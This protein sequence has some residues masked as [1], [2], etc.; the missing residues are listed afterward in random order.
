MIIH[1]NLFFEARCKKLRDMSQSSDKFDFRVI[2]LSNK[3]RIV[4]LFSAFW[5]GL[6]I[7]P[8]AKT[9]SSDIIL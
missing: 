5:K 1:Y 2:N 6:F 8:I 9:M 3:P 4:S 7:S